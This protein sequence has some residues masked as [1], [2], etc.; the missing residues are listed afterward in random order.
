MINTLIFDL[1]LTLIDSLAA[2]VQGANLLA[3][4]FGLPEVTAAQALKAISLPTEDFWRTLWG[5]SQKEWMDCFTREI[6]PSLTQEVTI[7][8]GVE[9][10]LVAARERGYLLAV[11]TNRANPWFDLAVLGLAKY[12]DTA[13]GVTD[14]PRPKPDPDILLTALKQLGN[15]CDEAVYIGDS[16][17][18]IEAARAAGIKGLGLYQGGVSSE[19]LLKAGAWMTRPNLTA[20]RDLFNL[21]GRGFDSD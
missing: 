17:V 3:R 19:E 4:R 21:L 9:E 5:Q 13:V 15:G 20:C 2:C 11:G 18:D 14:V 10:F 7:Y 12:F 1:D 8:P 16:L 6:I